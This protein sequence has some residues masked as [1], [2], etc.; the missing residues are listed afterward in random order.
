MT[1]VMMQIRNLCLHKVLR[2]HH[3]LLHYARYSC[4]LEHKYKAYS[5]I[6]WLAAAAFNLPCMVQ[7]VFRS[8]SEKRLLGTFIA[9]VARKRLD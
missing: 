4:G 6:D 1:C 3:E 9:A 2:C 7:S 8:N 5:A